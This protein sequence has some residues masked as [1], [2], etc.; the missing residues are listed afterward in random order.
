[1]N[2]KA[3]QTHDFSHLV[4]A[5]SSIPYPAL[6]QALVS[7][8]V[9]YLVQALVHLPLKIYFI[10]SGKCIPHD[11]TRLIPYLTL[12]LSQLFPHVIA[13]NCNKKDVLFIS[14]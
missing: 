3:Q 14:S 1:M 10:F 6:V 12:N 13:L 11:A 4:P 7:D 2:Q 9:F 5:S 8:L